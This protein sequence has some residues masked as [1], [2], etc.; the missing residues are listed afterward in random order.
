M[1]A[2]LASAL[3]YT[4]VGM[5]LPALH[6]YPFKDYL[7]VEEMS[8]VK[9]EYLDGEIYA[10]AG[11]SPLHAALAATLVGR[12][13]AAVRGGPCR[14]FTPDLRIRVLATGLASYPDAAVVCGAP[15]G[16]P[17]SPDTV[18]NPTVLVEVLSNSTMEYDLGEKFE[19]YKR[20]DS[21]RA[22]VYVWQ[23]EP[24]IEIRRRELTDAW[25]S[26]MAGPHE[27]AQLEALGCDLAVDDLYREATPPA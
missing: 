15:K 20:I 7:A 16:D 19:H 3:E 21:L 14:V 27:T 13:L 18:T 17:E 9:H 1:T 2:D 26:S 5:A 11:G 6:R 10:M 22:V 25:V 4:E 23:S 12:L 8:A 24:R